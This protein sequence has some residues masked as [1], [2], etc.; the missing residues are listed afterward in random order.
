MVITEELSELQHIEAI[1]TNI[2][3][4]K[5]TY[6]LLNKIKLTQKEP[7]HYKNL[8]EGQKVTVKISALKEDGNI[9][10][11]KYCSLNC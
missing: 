4:N 9:K 7:K 2:K 11:I 1:V 5:I 10:K 3:N 8:K 6:E